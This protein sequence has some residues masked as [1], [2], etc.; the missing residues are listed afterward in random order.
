MKNIGEKLEQA[1]N[2]RGLTLKDAVMYTK[3][4]QEFLVSMEKNDFSFNLP[5]VYRRGFLRLYADYLKL[6]A[7]EIMQ[8]YKLMQGDVRNSSAGI[9]NK[10]AQN[11]T[12]LSNEALNNTVEADVVDTS[13][14]FDPN[15]DYFESPPS[16]LEGDAKMNYIKIALIGS[17]VFLGILIIFFLF[18]SI[19]SNSDDNT[20]LI[21]NSVI[22]NSTAANFTLTLQTKVN[23]D[24][25]V[26]LYYD[27]QKN[28]PI[29]TG[30]LNA[31]EIK[32]F[33]IAGTGVILEGSDIEKLLIFKNSEAAKIS[34]KV[35][36]PFLLN[37]TAP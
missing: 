18:R 2:A 33:E 23:Q 28:N 6:N 7:D 26:I 3:I 30:P 10:I 19:L 35:K 12:M 32:D 17:S 9:L 11:D 15:T 36:G 16:P 4:K 27:G 13:E 37:I 5:D 14:R 1:R 29:Y 34:D 24:T 20:D 25:H 31:G 8:E 22:V 21:D